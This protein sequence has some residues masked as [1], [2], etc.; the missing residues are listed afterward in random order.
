M[1]KSHPSAE[2]VRQLNGTT[3]IKASFPKGPARD[4]PPDPVPGAMRRRI[5][6]FCCER[7]LVAS[8]DDEGAIRMWNLSEELSDRELASLSI[9]I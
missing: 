8:A 7:K 3:L 2:Y 1:T 6:P 9:S 5:R 4:L